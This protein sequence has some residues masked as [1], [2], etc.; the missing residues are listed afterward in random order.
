M[1]NQW[2]LRLP[3]RKGRQLFLKKVSGTICQ[4]VQKG[5]KFKKVSGTI[6][7]QTPAFGRGRVASGDR[8]MVPDTFFAAANGA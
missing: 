2:F 8:Q 5:V 6:C 3:P 4:Q 1:T 7:Q